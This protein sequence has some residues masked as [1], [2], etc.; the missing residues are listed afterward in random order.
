VNAHDGVTQW[1]LDV[2]D[3]SGDQEKEI[4]F[5]GPVRVGRASEDSS[6][7]IIVPNGFRSVS[8]LHALLVPRG[9]DVL[10]TDQSR[11]GTL[12]NGQPV[13]NCLVRLQSGDEVVFGLPHDGWRVRVRAH[14]NSLDITSSADPM[15]ML[16]VSDLPRQ[17]RVGRLVV[18]ESLGDRAFKL[19]MFLSGHKGEWYPISRL[20]TIVW[21]DI[22]S[23]PYQTQQALSRAK[24]AINDL[25]RPHLRGQDAIESRPFHG[26]RMKARLDNR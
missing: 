23:S 21:P 13:H 2:L 7:D 5:A 6:P 16:F 14:E 19:L 9:S 8:R 26:Y 24:R 20:E 4:A 22:D 18:E 25:L 3:V 12:V 11:F 10:L 15:E 1:F 17:V